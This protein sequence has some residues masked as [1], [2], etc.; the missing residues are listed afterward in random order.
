MY[1]HCF[2]KLKQAELS[3]VTLFFCTSISSLETLLL[4]LSINSVRFKASKVINISLKACLTSISLNCD[5]RNALATVPASVNCGCSHLWKQLGL[6]FQQLDF[7]HSNFSCRSTSQ[8][9]NQA[10]E[11]LKI[12]SSGIQH[13]ICLLDCHFPLFLQ[14]PFNHNFF[15]WVFFV[16][17]ICCCM[18]TITF[19]LLLQGWVFKFVFFNGRHEPNKTCIHLS[20]IIARSMT[21]ALE[22]P[23]KKLQQ[24]LFLSRSEL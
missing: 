23:Q 18:Y 7:N 13:L 6:R 12:S 22:N 10:M 8:N 5:P 16:V 2:P 3:A 11:I 14:Y 17:A 4:L 20:S 1:K 9:S 21:S 24:E 15:F 19:L